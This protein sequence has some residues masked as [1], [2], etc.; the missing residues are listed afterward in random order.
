MKKICFLLFYRKTIFWSSF[1]K[2][3]PPA[4]LLWDDYLLIF[5]YEPP[6][7]PHLLFFN[8]STTFSLFYKVLFKKTTFCSLYGRPSSGLLLREGHLLVFFYEK[9]NFWSSIKRPTA[10]LWKTICWSAMEDHLLIV[11]GRPPAGR[12]FN[13]KDNR[14]FY[15]KKT[16]WRSS[17]DD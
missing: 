5:F 6:A 16:T 12:V 9:A 4:L 7:D 1:M 2:I 15:K 14:I 10:R 11:F 8:E 3:P 13:K 17:I